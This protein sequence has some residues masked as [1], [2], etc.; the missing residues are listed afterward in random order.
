MQRRAFLL[1]FATA[2]SVGSLGTRAHAEPKTEP[3][4]TLTVDQVAGKLHAPKTFLFDNNSEDSWKAG[5]VPG[6]K[7]LDDEQV[8][9]AA[10]GPDKSATLIFYCHNET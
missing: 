3:L 9:A 8:T 4:K 2:I 5:H 1:L 6:A 7:W 10:L